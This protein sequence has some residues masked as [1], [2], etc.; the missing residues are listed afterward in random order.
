MFN[1]DFQGAECA[2]HMEKVALKLQPNLH[3]E[4]TEENQE[5]WTLLQFFA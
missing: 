3:S 2:H 5:P 1:V 4:N